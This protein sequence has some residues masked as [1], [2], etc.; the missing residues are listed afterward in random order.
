MSNGTEARDQ[1]LL[2]LEFYAVFGAFQSISSLLVT[3]FSRLSWSRTMHVL[4]MSL[5]CKSSS[6]HYLLKVSKFLEFDLIE[7]MLWC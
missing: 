5:K 4:N 1:S 2:R 3:L 7:C 6:F